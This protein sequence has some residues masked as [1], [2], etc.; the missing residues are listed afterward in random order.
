[1]ATP[2]REVAA[3]VRGVLGGELASLVVE[4]AGPIEAFEAAFGSLA[5]RGRLLVLGRLP[6]PA[7]FDTNVLLSKALSVIGSRGHACKDIFGDLIDRVSEPPSQRGRAQRPPWP[8]RS[9]SAR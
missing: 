9:R 6:A 2:G 1:M 4:A 5:N 3:A 8:A 7:S